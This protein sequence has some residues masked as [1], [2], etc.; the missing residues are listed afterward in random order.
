MSVPGLCD[1]KYLQR[2]CK[3]TPSLGASG[4]SPGQLLAQATACLKPCEPWSRP[5]LNL[6]S[7]GPLH[8]IAR[9]SLGYEASSFRMSSVLP[10]LFSNLRPVVLNS[11]VGGLLFKETRSHLNLRPE[12]SVACGSRRAGVCS[13]TWRGLWVSG[14]PLSPFLVRNLF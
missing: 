12:T 13:K 1:A 6:R 8:Q 3:W 7:C 14:T 11:P 4:L 10:A 9:A 5:C 2:L